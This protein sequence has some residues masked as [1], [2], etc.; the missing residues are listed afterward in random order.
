MSQN[1]CFTVLYT[2]PTNYNHG[3]FFGVAEFLKTNSSVIVRSLDGDSFLWE[4][5]KP[6]GNGRIW[7]RV[8]SG[9]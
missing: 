9:G 6:A 2:A 8:Q 7:R 1:R 5:R 3:C 4:N